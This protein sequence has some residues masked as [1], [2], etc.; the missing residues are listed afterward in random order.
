MEIF[1]EER[2]MKTKEDIL[3][4]HGITEHV[5]VQK[6]KLHAVLGKILN[7]RK[8]CCY[9]KECSTTPHFYLMSNYFLGGGDC[10]WKYLP[11]KEK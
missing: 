2:K 7:C 6:I 8:H 3:K 11:K 4:E 10:A 5:L 1:A 9:Y